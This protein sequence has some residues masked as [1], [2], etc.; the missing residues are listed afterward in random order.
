M[1]SEPVFRAHTVKHS[2]IGVPKPQTLV[3][4]CTQRAFGLVHTPSQMVMVMHHLVVRRLPENDKE[5][6]LRGPRTW[7]APFPL[8]HFRRCSSALLG[9]LPVVFPLNHF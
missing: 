5:E 8:G 9:M 3:Q 1:N 6:S 2:R 4:I 7:I